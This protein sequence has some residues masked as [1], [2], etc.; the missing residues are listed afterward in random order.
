[1]AGR[2]RLPWVLLVDDEPSI[3]D[4]ARRVLIGQ[5]WNVALATDGD[6]ALSQALS[7]PFELV[8]M[9]HRMPRRS[10]AATWRALVAQDSS[11]RTGSSC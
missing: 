4:L 3:R 11:Y 9:D 2:E 7:H 10:G 6:D 8:L 1:M 5:G